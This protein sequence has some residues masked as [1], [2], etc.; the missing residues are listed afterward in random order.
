MLRSDLHVDPPSS[1]LNTDWPISTTPA[2]P[3]SWV[4]TLDHRMAFSPT[5]MRGVAVPLD[6]EVESKVT[7]AIPTGSEVYVEL[8]F[9]K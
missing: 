8:E 3:I 9:W 1:D 4:Y 5:K 2:R 7:H 6:A